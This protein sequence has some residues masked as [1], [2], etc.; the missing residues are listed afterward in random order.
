MEAGGFVEIGEG[1]NRG[2]FCDGGVLLRHD[3]V[4]ATGWERELMMQIV[5]L[6][7]ISWQFAHQLSQG[8]K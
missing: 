8:A 7:F 6:D 4:Q 3:A 1:G 5:E 2:E